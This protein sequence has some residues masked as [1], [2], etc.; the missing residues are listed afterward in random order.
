[1][2]RRRFVAGLLMVGA[3]AS[4]GVA[5]A[6]PAWA[7]PSG[8]SSGAASAGCSLNASPP[9]SSGGLSGYGSRTGCGDTVNY[10]WVRVYKHIP[11]WPD[12]E[13]AVV[14]RT[15]W[16]NG[17]LAA[18]GGCGGRGEYYT[19]VST[20]TGVSGDERESGRRTIC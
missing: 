5:M 10:F 18:R 2:G 11:Y 6:S 12:S 14:G 19:F 17:G 20:A 16:Q 7:S 15:N 4:G 13:Q 8:T 9:S 1:M 3:I